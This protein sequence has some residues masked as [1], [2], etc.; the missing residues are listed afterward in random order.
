M[1]RCS[2]AEGS[3]WVMA[4]QT[5]SAAMGRAPV[6]SERM[7]SAASALTPPALVVVGKVVALGERLAPGSALV[8]SG[9]VVR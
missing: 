3:K 8:S 7:T 5:V 6:P 2:V 1:M 9:A 4:A